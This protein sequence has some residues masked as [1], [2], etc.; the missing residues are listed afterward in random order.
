MRL[1]TGI[2]LPASV[3]DRLASLLG[4]LRPSARLKWSVADN[5]HVTT[6]F[7]GE[8]PSQRLVELSAALRSVPA[9]APIRIA[10]RGLGWFPNPRA[11]RVFWAGVEAEPALSDLARDTERALARLGVALETRPYSPHLTLARVKDQVPLD[12]LRDAIAGIT[13]EDFGEF[14]ADRFCLYLSELAPSGSVYT[15]LE[16]FVFTR[17]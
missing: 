10:V 2:D 15:K 17:S 3:R 4:R 11:P 13:S 6:K 12:G 8:W 16:E 1:F 14:V 5:L 9:A 7:I